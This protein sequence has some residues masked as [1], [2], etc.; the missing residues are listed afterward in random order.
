MDKETRDL[1]L[2]SIVS[3]IYLNVWFLLGV[4]AVNYFY[5]KMH[6][7][8]ADTSPSSRF[9]L[10]RALLFLITPILIGFLVDFFGRKRFYLLRKY[11]VVVKLLLV[12]I[13]GILI[14]MVY[15]Q[16]VGILLSLV[17]LL[18]IFLNVFYIPANLSL[19]SYWKSKWLPLVM[20]LMAVSI[21]PVFIFE[22][23][24]ELIFELLGLKWSIVIITLGLVHSG[25]V[26]K[27]YFKQISTEDDALK[28][29]NTSWGIILW[30]AFILGLGNASLF[31]I[32]PKIYLMLN[33]PHGVSINDAIVFEKKLFMWVLLLLIPIGL[34]TVK[35]GVTKLTKLNNTLM[36][37][38]VF[39]AIIFP[40]YFYQ[41]AIVTTLSLCFAVTINLPLVFINLSE[42]Q[43]GVG[44]GV[45]IGVSM[46]L[47]LLLTMVY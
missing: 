28:K 25:Y 36:L 21:Y 26:F 29:I 20:A 33:E 24:I 4:V 46:F 43:R 13:S 32:Y 9:L 11:A 1:N 45:F 10:V 2:I 47:S 16:D 42:K 38:S 6:I 27:K 5:F 3:L 22:S 39:A 23:Y 37:L 17:L 14:Y 34:I 31:S 30:S 8:I 40:V 44:V 12:L 41:F 35:I 7:S 15:N 18:F 19:S